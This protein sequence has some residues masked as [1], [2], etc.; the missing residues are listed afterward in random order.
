MNN[1]GKRIQK[2]SNTKYMAE[3]IGTKYYLKANNNKERK[4]DDIEPVTYSY[5]KIFN[6]QPRVKRFIT[7]MDDKE[8]DNK[9]LLSVVMD[10]NGDTEHIDGTYV[11]QNLITGAL[12]FYIYLISTDTDFILESNSG[13]YFD[14]AKL[15]EKYKDKIAIYKMIHSLYTTGQEQFKRAHTEM[16]L[17]QKET[18][19]IYLDR[20]PIKEIG[21]TKLIVELYDCY[22]Y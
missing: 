18:Y 2:I 4:E 9:S 6:K 16:T 5:S 10:N 12:K 21:D 15:R 7:I 13:E 14:T 11:N 20:S 19:K 1:V 3:K 22:D 8:Y 17:D